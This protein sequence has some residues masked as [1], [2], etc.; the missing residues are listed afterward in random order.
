MLRVSSVSL[1]FIF[2]LQTVAEA[3]LVAFGSRCRQEAAFVCVQQLW[4]N[5]DHLL[6]IRLC[7]LFLTGR[8]AQDAPQ[9]LF[10][11]FFFLGSYFFAGE[12][13]VTEHHGGCP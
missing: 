4:Q 13:V 8:G 2:V 5:T 3:S 1:Y 12:Q 9:G 11:F 10:S 6:F 7:D